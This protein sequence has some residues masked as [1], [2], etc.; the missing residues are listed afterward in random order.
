[1]RKTLI[2]SLA[3]ASAATLMWLGHKFRPWMA[4]DRPVRLST[5]RLGD[6]EFQVW[7]RKNDTLTEPFATG[8]F[9]RRKSEQWK[10]FLLDFQDT[11]NP[12]I[13]LRKE[14]SG[15][16][17]LRWGK[18]LGTIDEATLTFKREPEGACFDGATI[19]DAPPATGG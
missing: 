19:T 12:P 1:M 16:V 17:V 5:T 10:A 13:R 8:L 3:L 9:V 14:S 18:R 11:Y 7:Q 2:V 4:P 6:C 15:F